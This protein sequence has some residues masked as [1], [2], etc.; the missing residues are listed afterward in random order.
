[1]VYRWVTSKEVKKAG[2]TEGGRA[3]LFAKNSQQQ[4]KA[5]R[6]GGSQITGK[7]VG[8]NGG[9][10]TTEGARGETCKG[11]RVVKQGWRKLH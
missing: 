2:W 4:V 3:P 10:G 6:K 8:G 9:R 5:A 11:K 1:M 7:E